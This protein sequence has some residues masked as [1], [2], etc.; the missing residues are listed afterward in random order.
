MSKLIDCLGISERWRPSPKN[1]PD[2][3]TFVSEERRVVCGGFQLAKAAGGAD[4]TLFVGGT[5]QVRHFD[6]IGR[7]RR[8]L[9]DAPFGQDFSLLI[10]WRVVHVD[11]DREAV[12]G[13]F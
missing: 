8:V 6:D 2:S 3:F 4:L 10:R 12:A 9:D 7:G 13:G 5:D 1:P 11:P